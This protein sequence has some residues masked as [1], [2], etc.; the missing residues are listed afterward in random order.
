MRVFVF[1]TSRLLEAGK[2]I[3]VLKITKSSFNFIVIINNIIAI[4]IIILFVII[5]LTSRSIQGSKD[6][7]VQLP[8]S[9][10]AKLKV[11]QML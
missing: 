3:I 10:P 7:I 5:Y 11:V 2:T 1:Q 9:R 6:F 4:A 8:E